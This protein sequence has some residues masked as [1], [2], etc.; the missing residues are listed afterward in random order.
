MLGL[1][2]LAAGILWPFL[3]NIGF[4]R[5]PGDVVIE[6]GDFRFY[7]PLMTSILLSIVFSI[8]LWMASR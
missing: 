6:R 2:I 3:G 5:L 8:V 1:V 4:G 7:F